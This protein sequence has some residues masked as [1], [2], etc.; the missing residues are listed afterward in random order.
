[1]AQSLNPID[2]EI[3]Q[4]LSDGACH[5]GS[6]LGNKLNIS[7]TAIWKHINQLMD[8][9]VTIKR[10][11]QQGY[12]L[13]HPLILLD[14]EIIKQQLLQLGVTT[15]TNI[16]LFASIGSTNQYLKD[17]PANQSLEICLAEHQ[18]QGRGRF[19]RY[20][21][22]PFGE[23]IY[24]SI[25]M[26]FPYDLIKLSGL[27]LITSLAIRSTLQQLPGVADIQIKWPNDLYWH[28]KKL[29]GSLIEI[30]AESN[31]EAEIIIG[32]GLNINTNT[33]CNQLHDKPWCSLWEITKSYHNRNFIIAA[34]IANFHSYYRQ[35]IEKGW[36]HFVDEWHAADYLYG[37][38]ICVAK[39]DEILEG[40]AQGINELG[41]L[42]LKD[43]QGV[44]H[45]LTSGDTTLKVN[46]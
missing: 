21:H 44:H 4:Q 13:E 45:V 23:N 3:L 15:P 28:E 40:I 19:G 38:L 8:L 7:R 22:S 39:A 36:Q 1:V 41:Q 31:G 16:N 46:T 5:S 33:I 18:S 6:A 25:R 14:K 35:F 42:I 9:G 34:L 27:A 32:T 17:L 2:R 26:R 10:L 11:P 24:C 37:K 30:M 12:Q 20:W 29:G 43:N